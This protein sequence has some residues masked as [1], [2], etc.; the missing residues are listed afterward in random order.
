MDK[1]P[2]GFLAPNFSIGGIFR[3][4]YADQDA[5][6]PIW[7]VTQGH[8]V[9]SRTDNGIH[10]LICEGIMGMFVGVDGL[11]VGWITRCG[12]QKFV[13]EWDEMEGCILVKRKWEVIRY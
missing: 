10:Y 12:G 11:F 9:G 13:V 4:P 2:P 3:I 7:E 1:R 8:A 6:S 5:I